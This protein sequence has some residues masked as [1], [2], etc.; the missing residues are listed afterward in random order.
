MNNKSLGCDVSFWQGKMNWDCARQ[1]GI[2]S[3]WYAH[4]SMFERKG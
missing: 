1:S 2:G 4:W 3:G